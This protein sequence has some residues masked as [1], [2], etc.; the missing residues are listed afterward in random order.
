MLASLWSGILLDDPLHASLVLDPILL[1][2]VICVGLGGRLGIWVVQKILNAE[3]DLLHSD[4]GLPSL[5]LVQDR[6]A[7][8][9]A[10]VDVRVKQ[11]RR[12]FACT[13]ILNILQ[14]VG[15]EGRCRLTL[16][17]L[18]RV[19]L[20]ED[21]DQLEKT[22]LPDGLLLPRDATLPLLDIEDTGGRAFGFCEEP[23]WV[24]FAPELSVKTSVIR[25]ISASCSLTARTALH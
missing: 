2:E 23:E 19:L 9:A 11:R 12:E 7:D 25:A 15:K 13:K 10:G 24:V 17:G 21:H 20:G 3:K 14:Y 1:E 5:L 4:G 18:G 6:Q 16:W 8:G 22:A